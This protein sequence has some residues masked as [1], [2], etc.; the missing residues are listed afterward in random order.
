MTAAH[1]HKPG[2]LEIATI[3]LGEWDIAKDPDCPDCRY[4]VKSLF[5][6]CDIRH[7][8]VQSTFRKVQQ[9]GPAEILIHPEWFSSANT[10]G[11]IALVRLDGVATT[12]HEDFKS[13]VLPICLSGGKHLVLKARQVLPV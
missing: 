2:R 12:V 9:F 4:F 3:S 7:T 5:R 13:E 6:H 1:C 10:Q 11:D 8:V